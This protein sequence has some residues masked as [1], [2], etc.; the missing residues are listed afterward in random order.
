MRRTKEEAEK[1][2]A[3][4][5]MAAETLFLEHGVAKTSLEHIARHAG[6]T[7]G[8]VYWHFENKAHLFHEMLNQVRLPIEQITE[9]LCKGFEN[10]PILA[11]RDLCVD[12]LQDLALNPQKQRIFT[13]L[14][15][16]CELTEE[17]QE[18][19]DRHTEFINQFITLCEQYFSQPSISARLQPGVTPRLAARMLN[20]LIVGMLSDSLRDPS[21][22]DLNQDIRPVFA[23]L[24][25]GLLRQTS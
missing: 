7:R 11:L 10:N 25:N 1:T 15:H 19:M 17:L 13:I 6:V 23:A 9:Q 20:A 18:A 14:L 24:F 8:A 22:F 3:A 16:R 2:R 4:I 12:A 21:L 5:L